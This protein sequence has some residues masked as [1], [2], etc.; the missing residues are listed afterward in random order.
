MVRNM[1]ASAR[2]RALTR[3]IRQGVNDFL[4][5][6]VGNDQLY[7]GAQKW[8]LDF[9]QCVVHIF[10]IALKPQARDLHHFLDIVAG[11]GIFPSEYQRHQPEYAHNFLQRVADKGGRHGA[12]DDDRQPWQV[13]KA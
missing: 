7:A 4:F 13:E 10:D 12:G 8:I 3:A 5:I 1:W 9:C 2:S 11:I 6:R